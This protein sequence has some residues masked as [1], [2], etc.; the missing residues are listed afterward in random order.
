MAQESPK[1]IYKILPEAPPQPIPAVMDKSP[2]DA[3]DGFIHLSAAFQ[4]PGT[5]GLFFKDATSVWL[6]KIEAGKLQDPLKWEDTF[7]HLYGDLGARDVSD[8]KRFDRPDSKTW[9]EVMAGDSW[10]E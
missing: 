8:S 4:V 1:Y 10:L 9:A 6:L 2:L 5:L 7:P 3:G